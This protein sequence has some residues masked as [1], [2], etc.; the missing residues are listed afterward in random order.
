M[1][2]VFHVR[3]SQLLEWKVNDWTFGKILRYIHCTRAKGPLVGN[4][5][6]SSML[7]VDSSVDLVGIRKSYTGRYAG[8]DGNQ[9]AGRLFDLLHSHTES[10][11]RQLLS[12]IWI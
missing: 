4:L 11:P 7:L 8:D 5:L 6:P 10:L 3:F 12:G 9:M 2:D 1:I